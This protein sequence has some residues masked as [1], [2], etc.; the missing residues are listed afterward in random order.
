MQLLGIILVRGHIGKVA[1][2]TRFRRTRRTPQEGYNL[3]SGAGSVRSEQRVAHTAGNALLRRPEDCIVVVIL[4]VHIG[5]EVE[6]GVVIHKDRLHRDLARRHG[7]G[8]L[9][10][11][12]VGQLNFPA[13]LIDN[14]DSTQIIPLSGVA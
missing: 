5:E 9:A 7:K 11:A 10:T 2:R 3:R 14:L 8:I 6:H 1:Q 12:L 13:V 4:R